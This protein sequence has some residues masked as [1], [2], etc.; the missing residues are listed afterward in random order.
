MNTW[1][2]RI[3][4]AIILSL[5]ATL[6][7][8]GI[9]GAVNNNSADTNDVYVTV[10]NGMV[11]GALVHIDR[12]AHF[13]PALPP[14]LSGLDYV[15]TANDD[16]ATTGL[17][18]DLTLDGPT[19]LYLSLDNRIG[20]LNTATPPSLGT[21]SSTQWVKDQGWAM[22]TNTWAKVGDED[23][24]Y[25]VYTFICFTNEFTLYGQNANGNMYSVA[26]GPF[27]NTV[28]PY[29]SI[30]IG[31]NGQR[32]EPGWVGLPDAPNNY[33]SGTNY[34]PTAIRTKTSD[35]INFS[36]DT[37]DWR[38][39]GNTTNIESLVYMAEDFVKHNDSKVSLTLDG[40]H[41]GHYSAT[42]YHLDAYATQS[43]R[44][45]V[46]V[47]DCVSSD[48]LQP[49][50]G[51]SYFDIGGVNNLTTSNINETAATFEFWANGTDPVVLRFYGTPGRSRDETEDETPIN[52]LDLVLDTASVP[53]A[54]EPYA[55]IDIG[56][57]E[58]RVVTNGI[59]L[60]G[61]SANESNN[62]NYGPTDLTAD[63][64]STFQF[65]I[66]SLNTNG[67][68]TGNIDWRDRGNSTNAT[69]NNT[70]VEIGEDFVKNSSGMVRVTLGG[71]KAGN[72]KITSFH[73]DPSFT[74][75][76]EILAYTTDAD[77]TAV[78]QT[79]SGDA[80]FS[81]KPLNSMTDESIK[82]S[83]TTFNVRSDGSSDIILYFDGTAAV[84]HETPLNGLQIEKIIDMSPPPVYPKGTILLLQ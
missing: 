64:D 75:C 79:L 6:L 13:F 5:S 9:T 54:L 12:T 22:T 32:I 41:K 29:A 23:N 44:I 19:M 17:S 20:N 30:D 62:Q 16:K 72:Y 37:I 52:G 60:P 66:D 25:T 2:H 49:T 39:K 76:E 74:Q 34:N 42:S 71:L 70:I 3:A 78:R 55:L 68:K 21:G 43:P 31:P 48:R 7:N 73:T 47:S 18:V 61:A 33:A 14:E 26:G 58:Q 40:L 50:F 57:E 36:I 28:I 53:P 24:P 35:T 46:F 56:P 10:Q 80:G 69:N 4:I 45:Q 81:T 67:V 84:D 83:A 82:G 8:A 77:G 1:S 63:D 59:A 51:D 15:K 27:T 65:T 38:D 11:Q